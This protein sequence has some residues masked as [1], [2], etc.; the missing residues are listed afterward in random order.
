MHRIVIAGS[1]TFKDYDLLKTTIE[2]YVENFEKEDVEFITS[3]TEGADQFGENWALENKY[4]IKIFY[5]D[6][7]TYGKNAE[8]R[9]NVD[10]VRYAAEEDG[11]LIA[12]WDGE[13]GGTKNIINTAMQHGLDLN[14]VRF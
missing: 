5:A 10:M 8:N 7:D 14:I 4:E 6:Y 1:K 11:M 12:F 3:T 9:C 13:S 2:K